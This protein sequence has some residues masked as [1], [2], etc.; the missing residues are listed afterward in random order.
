MS[1][2]SRLRSIYSMLPNSGY[3][4]GWTRK[5]SIFEEFFFEASIKA[6]EIRC[7]VCRWHFL[8]AN[9]NR[10]CSTGLRESLARSCHPPVIL[11]SQRLER[12]V[13]NPPTMIHWTMYPGARQRVSGTLLT[14]VWVNSLMRIWHCSWLSI[15]LMDAGYLQPL[16][17][18]RMWRMPLTLATR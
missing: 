11:L 16:P 10:M 13:W 14:S 1:P 7:V 18:L 5:I 15:R 12:R 9:L 6:P 4:T 17:F 3:V 2:S 8:D